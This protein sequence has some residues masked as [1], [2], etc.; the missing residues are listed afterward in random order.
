VNPIASAQEPALVQ[1]EQTRLATERLSLMRAARGRFSGTAA[2]L[3]RPL[4][5]LLLRLATAPRIVSSRFGFRRSSRWSGL[6]EEMP[7]AAKEI[8]S[9]F[10][11]G[12]QQAWERLF[13]P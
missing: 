3:R 9:Q 10:E 5:R 13:Q 6:A 12:R 7:V 8:G 4:F 1:P 11:A 2:K